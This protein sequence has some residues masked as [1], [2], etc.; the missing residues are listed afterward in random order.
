[1]LSYKPRIYF[2]HLKTAFVFLAVACSHVGFDVLAPSP[3]SEVGGVSVFLFCPGSGS[4]IIFPSRSK[5][6]EFQMGWNFSAHCSCPFP[7][8][9]FRESELSAAKWD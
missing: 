2:Q 1:M 7:E 9:S 5:K 8:Y 3:Q 6:I 4:Q